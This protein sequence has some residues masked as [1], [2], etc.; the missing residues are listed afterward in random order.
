VSVLF[1]N[2]NGTF[3]TRKIYGVGLNPW[4]LI[5]SDLNGDGKLDL[6][7]ADSGAN[8]VT[9]LAG[10]MGGKFQT[11]ADIRLGASTV[12]IG[13]TIADFNGDHTPD[14]SGF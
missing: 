11:R 3:Q 10:E 9:I 5:A 2:G 8:S 13:L 12:P 4:G 1:G 14:S 6:L 7:A